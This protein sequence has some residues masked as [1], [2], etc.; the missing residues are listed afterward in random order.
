MNLIS[1]IARRPRQIDNL[2]DMKEALKA[3]AVTTEE[4]EGEDKRAKIGVETLKY[5]LNQFG[6][7]MQDH[8]IEEILQDCSDLIHHDCIL[9]DDFANY[10]MNRWYQ[11]WK[12]LLK[13]GEIA[14]IMNLRALRDILVVEFPEKLKQEMQ[15]DFLWHISFI[16]FF[17]KIF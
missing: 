7:K 12:Y 10:L 13:L 4:E 1:L 17:L 16:L 9:I 11:F 2:E 8:E 14:K 3:F 6:E 15:K 5:S